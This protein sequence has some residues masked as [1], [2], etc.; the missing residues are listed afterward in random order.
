MEENSYAANGVKHCVRPCDMT[1][2]SAAVILRQMHHK[3]VVNSFLFRAKL[4]DMMNS[5]ISHLGFP[6]YRVLHKLLHMHNRKEEKYNIIS[7]IPKK[8]LVVSDFGC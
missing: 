5:L 4:K 8:I 2:K 3:V 6:V 1:G 7:T